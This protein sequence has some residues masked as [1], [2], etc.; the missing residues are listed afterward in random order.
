MKRNRIRFIFAYGTLMASEKSL[1]GESERALITAQC[2]PLGDAAIRGR[3]FDTGDY[4]GAVLGAAR[5]ERIEGEL[6]QLPDASEALLAALDRYEGC[7]PD[8]PEPQPYARSRLRIRTEDG[9]RVTAWIYL[10]VAPTDKLPRIPGGRWHT[11]NSPAHHAHTS[12]APIPGILACNES[13]VHRA[14]RSPRVARSGSAIRGGK[15][16]AAGFGLLK[17]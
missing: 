5:G 7:A 16:S 1:R 3:M 6:W 11:R 13:H 17:K 8:S 12:S 15:I 2:K 9:R 14:I 4:P 10:W